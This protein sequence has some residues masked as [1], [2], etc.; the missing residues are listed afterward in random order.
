LHEGKPIG[1]VTPRL[2]K[3]EQGPVKEL[4]ETFPIHLR[5]RTPTRDALSFMLMYDFITLCV[6]NDNH[7]FL[8]TV[9]YNDIQ[10]KIRQSYSSEVDQEGV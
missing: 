7:E 4:V 5:E 6:V 8:G 10:A 1:Y 2:L 9:T 3:Y